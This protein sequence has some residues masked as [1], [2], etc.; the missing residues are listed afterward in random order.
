MAQRISRA[1]QRI[2]AGGSRSSMPAER[3]RDGAAARRAAR[4]LPDLQRGLRG[5]HRRRACGAP[6][7]PARR[8]GWRGCCARLLP[9]EGEVAGL[10]ALMLLTDAAAPPAPTPTASWCRSTEQDR[11]PLG[12]RGD[13]GGRRAASPRRSPR[14]P[15]A[16][17]SCRRRSPPLH[18]RGAARAGGH[19]LAADPRPLRAARAARAEP[20]RDAEPRRRG[21]D[22]RRA[23]GGAASC[24][25]RCATTALGDTTGS[26]AVRAPPA[27]AGGRHAAG[28]DALPRGRP[29]RTTSMPEQRY[30]ERRAAA[31]AGD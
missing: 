26:H 4:A 17:T 30:L 8:S 24:W 11:T 7:S 22:G 21:G 1:K 23:R 2:E 20:D 15:S 5:E 3:E 6:S 16:P 29:R 18:D 28:A 31:I 9:E 10:L 25:R 13:R 12:P 27:R 19:R 14:A